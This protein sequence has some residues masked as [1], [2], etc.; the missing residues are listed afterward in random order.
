[1][2]HLGHE[3]AALEKKGVR[4][5]RGDINREIK[6]RNDERAERKAAESKEP[7][8][9][10]SNAAFD[11]NLPELKED[12]AEPLSRNEDL[13]E[14]IKIEKAA[15]IIENMKQERQNAERRRIAELNRQQ[16][17]EL[18]N[19]SEP[20]AA[21]YMT[22]F[23]KR[24]KAE[25]AMQRIE[26]MQQR[27][28]AVQTDEIA[29]RL[30]ELKDAYFALEKEKIE[31]IEQG[32]ETKQEIHQLSYRTEN[33]D[34][35]NRT[36]E[37]LQDKFE[38]LQEIRQNLR[39]WDLTQKKKLAEDINR[40]Q[41]NVR[42]KQD[43]FKKKYQ[44][45]PAQ[46][47]TELKRLLEIARIK[48]R[49]LIL[50]SMRREKIIARQDA[51]RLEYHTQKLLNDTRPDKQQIDKLLEEMREPPG[52]VLDRLQYEQV[53]RRLN[54]IGDEDF[55]RVVDNLPPY[56]AQI[57]KNIREQAK[58]RELLI[59]AERNRDRTFERSR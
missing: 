32:N 7:Q 19:P 36:I 41:Q 58:E 8:D 17:Q 14:Y 6:R 39:V 3:A 15:Q 29:L 53:E 25:K 44:L 43:E 28:N 37:L 24:F 11:K 56:E 57:L 55:Q 1:M 46:A 4:T 34:T 23:E 18:E 10:D 21:Q 22:E 26:K 40:V 52:A 47:Q 42:Q 27:Q 16:R 2:I 38:E 54:V 20:E 12:P 9:I 35:Y 13:D 49:D 59:E 45:D 50:K 5:E 51:V 48:E 30:H 31:L 33:I